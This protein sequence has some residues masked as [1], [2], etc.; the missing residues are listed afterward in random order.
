MIDL[1]AALTEFAT[2]H[3]NA[4][5]RVCHDIGIPTVTL[6]VLGMLA[7][8]QFGPELLGI[9]RLDVALVLLA[10][11]FVFDLFLEWRL[12]PFV[13]LIGLACWGIGREL[14]L[15]WLGVVFV[16]GW[17][18][19]L[20]GHRLAEGNAPAFRTNA[21]HLVVG[22]RWLVNRWLRILPEGQG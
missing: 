14:S 3:T 9:G 20:L 12:A 17:A 16:I 7:K 8:L 5:N 1:R 11:T 10:G 19:Q 15:P 22:P 21:V 13:A 18:F 2:W 6:A 4:A